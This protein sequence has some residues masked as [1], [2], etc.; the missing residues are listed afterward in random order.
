MGIVL[1]ASGC[2]GHARYAV[3]QGSGTDPVLPPPA[4]SL[5]PAFDIAPAAG[6]PAGS[7]PVAAT[8]LQVQA[9]ARGL[10]NPRWLYVLP[11]G[12][13]LVA[14]AKAPAKSGLPGLK[15]MAF[16]LLKKITSNP[17]PSADRITLLRDTD[18]DGIADVRSDFLENLHSPFGM[19]LV[20][21]RFY[22]ANTDAVVK[23]PYRNGMTA[24]QAAPEHVVTLPAGTINRHWTRNIVVDPSG[25]R[26]FVTVGSNS[27]IAEYGMDQE[28]GRAAVH[29]LDLSSGQFRLF[30]S[31]LRN[32]N[33]LD[34]EP[35]T[36]ALWVTVNER[37]QLG[38]DLVPDYMTPI[39]DGQFYGWPYSYFG[40]NIDE[41]VEPQRPDLVATA[42]VPDYALGPH[43]ASLGL[44][45]YRHDSFPACYH[46]GAFVAQRGSWNRRPPSGY[47]V[48]FVP[49]TEGRPVGLPEDV[50]TGFLHPDGEALGRP[51]GL[52]VAADG[53]LLVADDVG[54]TVWRVTP[55]LAEEESR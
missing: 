43:T 26:L 13:V 14:E 52:A 4:R 37:D 30:A 42:V 18:A 40:Q 36:G 28:I 49:F 54:R 25:Q 51:V 31:G 16:A 38:S 19:A 27:N 11:N 21:D 35:V 50:L 17:G 24:I 41:R 53:A 44:V 2:F 3:R 45:F 46:G 48:V 20:G 15:G 47:R 32:P 33:G 6:W 1:L 10:D 5:I 9:F 34:F 39:S 12:D 22:V 55:T 8:G 23:F 7:T 29:V